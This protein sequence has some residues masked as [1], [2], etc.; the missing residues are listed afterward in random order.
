MARER[1]NHELDGEVRKAVVVEAVEGNALFLFVVGS[2]ADGVVMIWDKL[3]KQLTCSVCTAKL[4]SSNAGGTS[5]SYPSG[6]SWKL[7]P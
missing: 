3:F 7:C 2:S 6:V 5:S 1:Y 4:V